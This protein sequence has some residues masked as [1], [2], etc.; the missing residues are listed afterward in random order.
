MYETAWNWMNMIEWNWI[1]ETMNEWKRLNETEWMKLNGWKKLK[2]AYHKWVPPV[3][4]HVHTRSQPP[5]GTQGPQRDTQGWGR[6]AIAQSA[7]PRSWPR[8][9][10]VQFQYGVFLQLKCV[11]DAGVTGIG[12]RWG[13]CIKSCVHYVCTCEKDG[14]APLKSCVHYALVY[15]VRAWF[16]IKLSWNNFQ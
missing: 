4:D 14:D 3:E 8:G 7:V 2:K 15:N 13:S 10:A 12:R 16:S 11:L 9:V 1:N 6:G 5:C